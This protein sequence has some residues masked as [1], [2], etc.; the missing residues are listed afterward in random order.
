MPNDFGLGVSGGFLGV[1]PEEEFPEE[2]FPLSSELFSAMDKITNSSTEHSNSRLAYEYT[3]SYLKNVDK[4]LDSINQKVT[5]V[6]GSTGILLKFAS[7]LPDT[8]LSLTLYK[9]GIC[10]LLVITIILCFIALNP[11]EAGDVVYPS[12]LLDTEWFYKEDDEFRLFVARQWVEASKQL[13][14]E[15]KD[16]A[17]YLQCCYCCISIA[18]ILFAINIILNT[19]FSTV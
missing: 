18:A 12:E 4:G 1:S 5:T 6:L 16:K 10:I 8:Y 7:D 19:I 14:K 17:K 15:Y 2:A 13:E 3:E 9:I 11:K